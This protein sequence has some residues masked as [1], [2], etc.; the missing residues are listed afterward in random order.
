[1]HLRT[2]KR[3]A[4]EHGKGGLLLLLN[5]IAH[6][7]VAG[8]ILGII[9][10]CNRAEEI[11]VSADF[12]Q[13]FVGRVTRGADD[14]HLLCRCG[15]DR[16]HNVVIGQQ[17]N[18]VITLGSVGVDRRHLGGRTVCGGKV[19][20]KAVFLCQCAQVFRP[21]RRF[22][23]G[24][25][26][27]QHAD[28]EVGRALFASSKRQKRADKQDR[29]QQ[30]NPKFCFHVF[31]PFQSFHYRSSIRLRRPTA[32]RNTTVAN[33]TPFTIWRYQLPVT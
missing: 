21:R 20:R 2:V 24:I 28:F 12:F 33:S 17:Q 22:S 32:K 23:G 10:G 16:G 6:H 26:L 14:I 15:I 30:S 8:G 29:T 11:L 27:P 19:N 31:I 3:C 1:M 5:K 9:G 4:A 18:R 25:V 7:V 13:L